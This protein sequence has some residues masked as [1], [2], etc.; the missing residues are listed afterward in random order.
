MILYVVCGVT[1]FVS[2]WV[3]TVLER[4]LTVYP[5]CYYVLA[6]WL[7]LILVSRAVL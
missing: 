1:L 5:L 3:S 7:Y 6:I 2:S 4:A